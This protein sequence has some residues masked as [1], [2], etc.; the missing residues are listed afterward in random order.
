M[1]PP[2][3]TAREAARGTGLIFAGATLAQAFEYLYR[4]VL[5]RGLGV[6]G[7]GTFNEARSALLVLA[8]LATFGLG[9]GV[10]R[11][12]A[13]HRESGRDVPD[14]ND[15]EWVGCLG[16]LGVLAVQYPVFRRLPVCPSAFPLFPTGPPTLNV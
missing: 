6:D 11:F 7:F 8:G 5:A 1:S 2:S 12:V 13:M 9:A 16:V 14:P 10:K 3:D 4:F 15:V